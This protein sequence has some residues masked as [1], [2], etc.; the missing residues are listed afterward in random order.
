MSRR[1]PLLIVLAAWAVRLIYIAQIRKAPYFDVPLIDGANYFHMASLIASGDLLGGPRVFWQPPLYPYF[2][3]ALLS[4]VGRRMGI[5]YA[6]QAAIGSLSCL[7]V[8]AIG[9]RL[10]SERA[11]LC[12]AGVMIL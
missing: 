4:V 8:Y 3:A 9:R 1:R 10:F 11:A 6:I 5:V 12:A 7:L 2:L